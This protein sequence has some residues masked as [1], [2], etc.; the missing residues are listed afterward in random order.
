[1]AFLEIIPV[2]SSELNLLRN[3][4]INTF[5]ETFGAQNT[6]ANIQHY[7]ASQMSVTQLKKEL[8]SANSDFY[9]AYFNDTLVGYLKLNYPLVKLEKTEKEKTFEIQRIYLLKAFQRRG[10]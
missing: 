5:I 9:F 2:T 10:F 1:M 7:L 4:S 3:L 6:E 8:Q